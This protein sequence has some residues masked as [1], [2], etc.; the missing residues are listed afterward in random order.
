ME[1]KVGDIVK[2]NWFALE[3]YGVLF[4]GVELEVISASDSIMTHPGY[5]SSVYPDGL[6]DLRIVETGKD[7]DF[8]LYDFELE[9]A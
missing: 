5:D 9:N 1:H 2:M 3:N 7:L 8:S 4:D 6:Y